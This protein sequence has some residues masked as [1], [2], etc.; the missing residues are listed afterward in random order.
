MQQNREIVSPA[1]VCISAMQ[2]ASAEPSQD[3]QHRW[4]QKPDHD[5]PA[6]IC[7]VKTTVRV[8]PLQIE[9]YLSKICSL[10]ALEE[11]AHPNSGPSQPRLAEGSQDTT[12][13]M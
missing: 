9:L 8:L 10:P 11:P 4:L 5:R 12:S 6:S 2:A 13:N 3:L 1:A 7:Q